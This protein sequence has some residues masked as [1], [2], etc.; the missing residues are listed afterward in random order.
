MT[1]NAVLTILQRRF[2][3]A[4]V[5]HALPPCIQHGTAGY[6][7]LSVGRAAQPRPDWKGTYGTGSAAPRDRVRTALETATPARMK[8]TSGGRYK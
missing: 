6:S 4:I 3:D 5:N 7:P 1:P 2:T 8:A